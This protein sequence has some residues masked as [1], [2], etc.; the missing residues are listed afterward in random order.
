VSPLL[1]IVVP[2]QRIPELYA[3]DGD[4]AHRKHS[5]ASLL[6]R[7]ELQQFVATL[8]PAGGYKLVARSEATGYAESRVLSIWQPV[9]RSSSRGASV[10]LVPLGHHATLGSALPSGADAGCL[11]MELRDTR[12]S[13]F[14]G[15]ASV[16]L[17]AALDQLLPAP[18][19]YRPIWSVRGAEPLTIW[20]AV[21]PTQDFVALG[22]IATA[23]T[24]DQPPPFDAL[25][26]VPKAWVSR[27]QTTLLWDRVD[28]CVWHGSHGL[29]VGHK[30]RQAP[31]PV[32]GLASHE[33]RGA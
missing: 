12:G 1:E 17:Q 28:G 26:C 33:M 18:G 13:G 25:R 2:L 8:R 4:T 27:A 3:A 21:P 30:G 14:R 10:L 19:R 11:V 23:T 31:A 20:S 32:Y 24:P 29:M 22:S 5:I 7:E 16:R 15:D 6:T 9:E